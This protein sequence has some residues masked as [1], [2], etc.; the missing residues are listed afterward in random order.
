MSFIGNGGNRKFEF[1]FSCKA[2]GEIL[3]HSVILCV[4]HLIFGS[5]NAIYIYIYIYMDIMYVTDLQ[6]VSAFLPSSG[7]IHTP[8]ICPL[9]SVHWPMITHS[10]IFCQSFV[11]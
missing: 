1:N 4:I 2:T 5:I 10:W 7:V 6:H 9:F 8:F 3:Y 11:Y